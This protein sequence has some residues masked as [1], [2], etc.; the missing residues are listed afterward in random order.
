MQVNN[1]KHILSGVKTG[2][3]AELGQAAG[4]ITDD[5]IQK[6]VNGLVCSFREHLGASCKTIADVFQLEHAYLLAV[7]TVQEDLNHGGKSSFNNEAHYSA[8]DGKYAELDAKGLDFLS[9]LLEP[10]SENL[11]ALKTV[12]FHKNAVFGNHKI[13]FFGTS[14]SSGAETLRQSIQ[15]S[16][17]LRV[18]DLQDTHTSQIKNTLDIGKDNTQ[19][20]WL[21]ARLLHPDTRAAVQKFF[22]GDG[23]PVRVGKVQ[24]EQ[25]E[26]KDGE[27]QV[28]VT[29]LDDNR[30][31]ALDGTHDSTK[32]LKVKNFDLTLTHKELHLLGRG[33]IQ[34][35]ADK[36]HQFVTNSRPNTSGISTDKEIQGRYISGADTL[37]LKAKVLDQNTPQALQAQ[38]FEER[39][40]LDKDGRIKIVF[41]APYRGVDLVEFGKRGGLIFQS[42]EDCAAFVGKFAATVVATNNWKAPVYQ[43]KLEDTLCNTQGAFHIKDSVPK[44]LMTSYMLT[45]TKEDFINAQQDLVA[46]G[47]TPEDAFAKVLEQ[48]QPQLLKDSI[49][50]S[51]LKICALAIPALNFETALRFTVESPDVQKLFALGGQ[52]LEDLNKYASGDQDAIAEKSQKALS[53]YLGTHGPEFLDIFDQAAVKAEVAN[54]KHTIV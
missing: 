32:L 22:L 9:Q 18:E 25:Q 33:F 19:S 24:I 53:S 44:T 8:K 29:I 3:R 54:L 45:K 49:V 37:A 14:Y 26:E 39:R 10:K 23:A 47:Y 40:I 21:M 50:I 48:Y 38:G 6:A 30:S 1:A 7:K 42:E 31:Y 12:C 11:E 43:L 5:N 27:K 13:S 51:M 17:Q 4:R 36:I 46:D 16:V 20:S 15:E 28:K 52:G 34:G 41:A 2:T 35:Y